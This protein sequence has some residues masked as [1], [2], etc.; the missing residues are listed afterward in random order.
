MKKILIVDDDEDLVD[1]VKYILIPKGFGVYAHSNGFKVPDVVKDYQPDM[2]FM[3]I[4][5]YGASG[6]DICR[7]LKR[8]YSTPIILFSG[9]TRKGEGFADCDADGFLAKPFTLNHLLD[10]I[11]MHL[12]P[13][14]A[15]A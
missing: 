15:L 9:D 3:D 10:T 1:M 5:L 13:S 14:G 2:I 4:L 6:I 11:N 7:Q 8:R 12:H